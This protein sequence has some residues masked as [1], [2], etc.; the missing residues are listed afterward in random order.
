M[1]NILRYSLVSFLIALLPANFASAKTADQ[2]MGTDLWGE[3]LAAKAAHQDR[4]KND[5]MMIVIDYSKH[6]SEPRFFLIDMKTMQAEAF[7]VSHGRNSDKNHDGIADA[8]S[9]ISGSKMT[10]LGTYVTAETYYGK[11]G[12]SLRLDG[13]D[14]ENSRARERAIVI[15]GADYVT[16]TRA[17]MGR[18]WGCPALERDVA[19]RLIPAIADGVLIYVRGNVPNQQYAS[20]G[21]AKGSR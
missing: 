4:V 21:K 14:R 8:F 18:S 15:H 17:K 2:A 19:E 20:A 9:N 3:A 5:D 13:L 16:P 10:S 7:L 6:S 11:H 1:Q 12:L